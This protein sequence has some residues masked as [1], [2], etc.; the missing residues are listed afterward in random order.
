MKLISSK[1]GEAEG[2]IL[3]E[4]MNIALF[5]IVA[6][7][8]IGF[9]VMLYKAFTSGSDQGSM[10]SLSD[11]ARVANGLTEGK[12]QE[13]L[14][15]LK[16]TMVLVGYPKNSQNS[17]PQYSCGWNKI[18]HAIGFGA[19]SVQVPPADTCGKDKTCI[20]ICKKT[21][22]STICNPA[23]DCKPLN[24]DDIIVKSPM[25]ATSSNFGTDY[26]GANSQ[27]PAGYYFVLFNKCNSLPNFLPGAG[28]KP[29]TKMN[30]KRT[31]N[32]L[33]IEITE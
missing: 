16:E 14:F 29:M 4:I 2:L 28:A 19:K 27:Y 31:G 23:L 12:S 9:S 3:T 26:K 13:G 7:A 17:P 24:Y 8:L 5:C 11:L 32:V 21:F 15:Y 10:Q 1:K 30:L 25:G 18:T 20:C 6:I 33:E 22:S